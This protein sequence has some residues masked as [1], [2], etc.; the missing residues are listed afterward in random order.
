MRLSSRTVATLAC[1]GTFAATTAMLGLAGAPAGAAGH[2]AGHAARSAA[3]RGSGPVDVL[4][5]G[6]LVAF[7]QTS[8]DAAF[9]Q[10]TGYTV[11]GISAGSTALATEIK[12]GVHVADV[13]VSA[14]PKSDTALEGAANG[15]WVKWYAT[16]AT[17]PLLI[18][19]NSSSTFAATLK[20]KPWWKVV[21]TPGFQIG[22]TNPVTDPKGVLTVKAVDD[23]AKKE[24]DDALRSLVASTSNIFPE[25]TMVGRL[26]SGQLD[27]GFFYGVEAS[28][29]KLPTV[30][31]KGVRLSAG[32][33]VTVVANAPH[34]AAAAAFVTFLLSSKGRA[35]LK[36]NGMT[37]LATPKVSGTRGAIPS[38]LK[39]A[40]TK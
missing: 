36:K 30:P 35:L 25:Q 31:L 32:Y 2:A 18:G 29:A 11:T 37:A 33:T 23:A 40:L 24:H 7:M 34:P 9:H 16:F 20:K 1:A 39:K 5:A 14:S 12:G 8:F 13:F 17:S 21:T 15:N 4:Y 10:A 26:Q 19:Y 6:S 38:A 3:G 22:R 27:A 28:A